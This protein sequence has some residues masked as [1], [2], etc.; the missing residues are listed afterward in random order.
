MNLS[1]MEKVIRQVPIVFAMLLSAISHAA[2]I[3]WT[4]TESFWAIENGQDA[5]S[6]DGFPIE[7]GFIFD[8]DIGAFSQVTIGLINAGETF[9]STDPQ[10]TATQILMFGDTFSEDSF[11]IG[12][13]APMTASGGTITGAWMYQIAPDFANL[14]GGLT[15][16]GVAITSDND[17]SVVPEPPALAL[18]ALGLAGARLNR[19]RGRSAD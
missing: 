13:Y 15:L 12:L 3:Q 10:S 11:F 2:P 9:S 17:A 19:K 8:A 6:P 4:I 16:Q 1:P 14:Q 18:L 7:G 5:P